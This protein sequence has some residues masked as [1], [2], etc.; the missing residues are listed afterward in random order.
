MEAEQVAASVNDTLLIKFLINNDRFGV[1]IANIREIIE[2]PKITSVPRTP[3]YFVGIVNLRGEII[4]VIDIRTRFGLEQKEYD[5]LSRIAILFFKNGYIGMIVD[6]VNEVVHV[7]SQEIQPTPALLKNIDTKYLKG[8][9]RTLNDETILLLNIEEILDVNEFFSEEL[10]DEL[11]TG[12]DYGYEQVETEKE[13]MIQLITFCLQ[14][15]L[16]A[17]NIQD[18]DEIIKL[19]EIVPIP[20]S[21]DFIRGVISLRGAVIPIVDF[22]IRFN[23]DRLVENE[24][25]AIIVVDIGNCEVGFIV[26]A[27]AEIIRVPETLISTPPPTLAKSEIDQLYGVIKLDDSD[28]SKIISYISLNNLF[29]EEELSLLTE[30]K[31]ESAE[32]LK[33]RKEAVKDEAFVVVNFVVGEDTFTI[34]V[35][36]VIE[37]SRYPELTKV[38]SAPSFVDG[39]INLRGDIVFVIDLRARFGFPRKLPDD[40]TRVVI[41]N[42]DGIKTGFI[43]DSVD[44][45]RTIYRSQME[46]APKI[47]TSIENDYIDSVVKLKDG[48]EMMIMLNLFSLLNS[49]EKKALVASDLKDAENES[50][51]EKTKK[52]KSKEVK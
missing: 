24:D 3:D 14:T 48:A 1:N 27:I 39:V 23:Y 6:D 5:E 18:A 15:E 33:S 36:V 32:S 41:A 12:S 34:P 10:E 2:I 9:V 35:E 8:V 26:D 31:D 46:P 28:H 50:E 25:T 38:P 20:Q 4:S 22:H 30:V 37:I 42:I 47:I 19:R 44:S 51:S 45:V 7:A 11:V 29:S 49:E 21:P 16:Y 52:D 43:V 17:I 40:N 13:E